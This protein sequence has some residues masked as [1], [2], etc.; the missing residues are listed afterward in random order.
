MTGWPGRMDE[1]EEE[2]EQTQQEGSLSWGYRLILPAGCL[3]TNQTGGMELMRSHLVEV[4][5]SCHHSVVQSDLI[6]QIL[7]IEACFQIACCDRF[8]KNPRDHES[9]IT[10]RIFFFS[11]KLHTIVG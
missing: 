6:C 1:Y 3:Q 4:I 10:K 9:Y 11:P 7:V 5:L 2:E 8:H